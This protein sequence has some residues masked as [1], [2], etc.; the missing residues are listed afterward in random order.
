MSK[1]IKNFE[2]SLNRLR[3]IADLLENDDVSLED[4]IKIYE[5][6]IKLSKYCSELL[7]NAEL[8]VQELNSELKNEIDK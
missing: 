2:D 5:E 8:K 1:K 6:G 4:S 7:T 3:E